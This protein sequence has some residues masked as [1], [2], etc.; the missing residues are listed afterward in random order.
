MMKTVFNVLFLLLLISTA[1]FLPGM[2]MALPLIGMT[3]I[4]VLSLAIVAWG[5]YDL[6]LAPM[7]DGIE[8]LAAPPPT[9]MPKPPVHSVTSAT[10]SA[11]TAATDAA[12][13]QWSLAKWRQLTSE[14]ASQRFPSSWNFDASVRDLDGHGS[15]QEEIWTIDLHGLNQ[16]LAVRA[17]QLFLEDLRNSGNSHCRIITGRGN[18]SHNGQAVLPDKIDRHLDWQKRRGAIVGF[19]DEDGH[20]DVT[21]RPCADVSRTYP[22]ASVAHWPCG[23]VRGRGETRSWDYEA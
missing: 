23:H 15:Y 9:A 19:S 14:A 8:P 6:L 2:N 13:V 17:T 22:D 18:N 4:G 5:L 10:A 7:L 3:P 21:L 12:T 1:G 16:H 20:F 11:P